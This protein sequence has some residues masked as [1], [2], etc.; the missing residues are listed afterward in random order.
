MYIL[1]S[2]IHNG[3]AENDDS[4][5]FDKLTKM[6]KGTVVNKN[7]FTNTNGLRECIQKYNAITRKFDSSLTID[8]S[9]AEIR[10]IICHGRGFCD[11]PSPFPKYL[12]NFT[13]LKNSNNQ[14][15][16]NFNLCI[17][18]EWIKEQV[19]SVYVALRTA[20]KADKKLDEIRKG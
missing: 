14:V 6:P 7:A 20:G 13:E 16:M 4:A 18:Y 1:K 17:T 15:E 5:N 8:E 12:M 9:I 2:Q 3:E 19:R 10:N 11:K